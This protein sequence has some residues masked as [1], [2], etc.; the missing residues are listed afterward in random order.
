M[1]TS[2]SDRGLS[3]EHITVNYGGVTAVDDVSLTIE[4]GQ[5]VGL[6]GPNGAGKTSFVDAITG[7]ST[8]SGSIS[9]NGRPI[10]KMKPHQRRH[11]GLSRTWQAGEL[12]GTLTVTENVLASARPPKWST[13]WTDVFGRRNGDSHKVQSILA[14]VGIEDVAD[15]QAGS[16]SLGQQKL[17]GVARAMAGG[18][19]VLLLDEPAAGLDSTESLELADRIRLLVGQELG[20]LLID[21]DVDLMLK[22]CD[23]VYVLEFGK[24]I[25][26][27][28]PDEMRDDP[29]VIEAY[30]GSP[31][32]AQHV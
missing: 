14:L 22:V 18:C 30:L 2:Q 20:A 4:P 21:H 3:A 9:L 11:A 24:L 28:T 13:L 31:V 26:R 16:L 29:R 1:T 25:F 12:F 6:I 7:F 15:E 23:I 8:A 27:G 32:E 17:V 5:V 19:S 10:E